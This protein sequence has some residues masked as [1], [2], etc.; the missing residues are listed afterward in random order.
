MTASLR[1]DL[2]KSVTMLSA[3]GPWDL[4][5]GYSLVLGI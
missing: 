5:I 2:T 1:N 4:V 3:L